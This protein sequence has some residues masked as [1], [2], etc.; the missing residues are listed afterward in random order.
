[1][2]KRCRQLL[3][4]TAAGLLSLSTTA[5]LSDESGKE[6]AS[7]QQYTPLGL[8][9]RSGLSNPDALSANVVRLGLGYTSDDNYMFGQYNGLSQQGPT[10]IADL[11]WRDFHSSD[12]YWDVSLSNL[13]LDTREGKAVWGRAGHLR[14]TL[15]FDSQQQVRNDSGQT[16]FRGNVNQYLPGNWVS[17]QTTNEF[18]ALD[19]ALRD[20]DRVL[21]RDKAYMGIEAK[22][23]EHWSVS[24]NLSYEHKEGHGDAGAGIYIDASGADAVLLRTPVDYGTTEFDIGVAYDAERLHL[25]GQLAYSKFDNDDDLLVWQNPYS[26]FGA[27][28][29]YPDGTG[30]LGLAPD[31]D[32]TSGRLTGSYLFSPQLRLQFD[33]SYAVASQDQ[34]Y[35]PYTVNDALVVTV[36]E[37]RSDFGGDVDTSTAHVRLLWNPLPKLSTEVFYKLRDRDYDIDRDGYLYVRG[38]GSN[39]PDA[40]M[41]VYNTDHDLTKQTAGAE[42][43]YRLPLRSKLS[44]EYAYEE[45]KRRNAPVEKTEED[46]YILGYRIQPWSNFTSRFKLEYGDRSADDYEW[47]QAYYALLDA[48]LINATPDNQRYITH[49][50]LMKYYMANR[51]RWE[52][53]ADFSYLPTARWNLNLNL[54]WRDDDYDASDLGL[55]EAEWYRGQFSV[56]YAMSDTF[57][58]TAYSGYDRYETDQYSRAFRGGSEKDAFDIYPPLPQASDPQQ[59][60]QGSGSDTSITVGANL[61]W[62]IAPEVELQLDYSYVDTRSEQN[63]STQPGATV[64]AS[65]LPDVNTTMHHVQASGIWH[66][67]DNLSLQ[68]DY[69]YYTFKSDDW[70]WEDVQAD[71]IDK[72]LTFGQSN[73]DEDIHY[74]GASVIYSWQ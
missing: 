71:T 69:Q 21:D 33:G 1:M 54:L 27:D 60:W 22:I 58:A 14:I 8:E 49:P 32:Q 18:L 45:V 59:D 41:T 72:V 25:N 73:P 31:N 39:Q 40:E 61:Q 15:G 56:S 48:E 35:A 63:M 47:A 26:S 62:Q 38:D 44:V 37:P 51:E 42:A 12:N 6:D 20:F 66:L 67:E 68:L 16:P 30:G 70:A 2:S 28:V 64:S 43:S 23:D 3:P 74:I 53:T 46:R 57:F 13:G 7:A 4:V 36:P 11:R 24:S 10:A 9:V 19:G 55:T 65:D 5:A 29:R 34:S 50:L 52:S 17:G